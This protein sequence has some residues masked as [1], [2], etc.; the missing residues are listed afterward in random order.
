M[1][2]LLMS[3]VFGGEVDCSDGDEYIELK[4]SRIMNNPK[5]IIN[6]KRFAISLSIQREFQDLMILSELEVIILLTSI[7]MYLFLQKPG[8]VLAAWLLKT[9]IGF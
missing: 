7:S 6:F 1:G 3:L 4:T 2:F 9:N 8:I 5:H